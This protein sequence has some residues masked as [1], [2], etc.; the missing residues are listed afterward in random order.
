M[1]ALDSLRNLIR[2]LSSEER[3][4]VRAYL[5]AFDSRGDEFE[6]KS[7]MLFDY[8]A[9]EPKPIKEREVEYFIYGKKSTIAWP[10]LVLRLREKILDAL[11]LPI[12]TSKAHL[13]DERSRRLFE[14]RRKLIR[15][16]FLFTRKFY[17]MADLEL[18]LVLELTS[19]IEAWEERTA[20]L[21]QRMEMLK[22]WPEMQKE[23]KQ[24]L[25]RQLTE[26]KRFIQTNALVET[27][28]FHADQAESITDNDL[29]EE[30]QIV[31]ETTTPKTSASAII[32]H[33][34]IKAYHY[35]FVLNQ[36]SK[37][38]YCLHKAM[39][40]L[41]K[42]PLVKP[43][44][45]EG[46]LGLRVA[47]MLLHHKRFRFAFDEAE[48]ALRHL[49][50][51][52]YSQIRAREVM[53]YAQC[54]RGD[55]HEAREV[56]EVLDSMFPLNTPE[57][58]C[59]MAGVYFTIGDYSRT[60]EMLEKLFAAKPKKSITPYMHILSLMTVLERMLA[61]DYV[62]T[63]AEKRF[64]KVKTTVEVEPEQSLREATILNLLYQLRRNAWS[65]KET[66]QSNIELI[67][68]LRTEESLKWRF[69]S[70]ELFPFEEWF[71]AKV[72]RQRFQLGKMV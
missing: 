30:V 45:Y 46:L 12:N 52:P 68:K 23:Y 49:H 10:R 22:Q 8:L 34:Q 7:L 47:E 70:E 65:F 24:K 4:I 69:L 28:L 35:T 38:V 67:E 60:E 9:K 14:I 21:Q 39:R 66:Y 62:T 15:A 6:S 20:A 51:Y 29:L 5:T 36:P 53:F 57:R 37:A 2:P 56:I 58:F 11:C 19:E 64:V 41:K 32:N 33:E 48:S 55:F 18:E 42:Y 3:K 25:I 26:C 16:Q 27:I 61:D 54:Y 1:S 71:M 13:F 40:L 72:T 44:G 50:H 31:L 43:A 17:E 59:R 63:E